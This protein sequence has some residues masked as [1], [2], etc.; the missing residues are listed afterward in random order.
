MD[1]TTLAHHLGTP[2]VCWNRCERLAQAF[3]R[4]SLFF[5]PKTLLTRS[6]D[7]RRAVGCVGFFWS[8]R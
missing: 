2:L 1:L 5:L 8:D 3:R 6:R 7:G 4:E